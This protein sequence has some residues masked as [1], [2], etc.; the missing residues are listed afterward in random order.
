MVEPV[1]DRVVWPV[2]VSLAECLCTQITGSGLPEPCFCGILPGGEAAY[3]YCDS[4]EDGTCGQ[5]WVRLAQAFPSSAF[6]VP[7]VGRGT[8]ASPLA[9]ELVV[10]IVRC[11]PSPDDQGNPPSLGDQFATSQL[12][13]A[14]MMAMRRAIMCC[15]QAQKGRDYTLGFY[16]PV[17]PEGGCVGGVWTATFSE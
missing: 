13:V 10:G 9:F 12:V 1:G 8:C 2:M 16:L 11:A 14:D 15:A 4:C 17:G 7:D 6:P 3:D 5:A